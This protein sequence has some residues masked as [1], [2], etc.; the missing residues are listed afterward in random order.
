MNRCYKR[1]CSAQPARKGCLPGRPQGA[2]RRSLV[3]GRWWLVVALWLLLLAGCAGARQ[4]A[5]PTSAPSAA[6]TRAGPSPVPT[7]GPGQFANPV[8]AQDFPDPD[9]LKVGDTYYAYATNA[10]G[11]NVQVAES[12]D[13]VAWRMLGDALPA[14]PAWA[15]PG[16][17]WA[18]EIAQTAGGQGFVLY[19]TARE[20]QSQR[21]C[22]GAATS[23]T[24]QGPFRAAGDAPLVCQRDEGG[25]IDPASFVDTDGTRYLLWKSDGNCCGLDTWLY[26]QRVSPD[27]LTLE[28]QPTRLIKQD[29]IWEGRLVEAPTLWKRGQT[30]YLFYS[31]NNYA[32]MDYAVGYATAAQPLGPYRKSPRPLAAS[33]TK[34]AVVIGPGGQD[35]AVAPDGSTWLVYHAWDTDLTYR[36]MNIDRLE[37]RD[38]TPVL[39]G[40]STGPQALP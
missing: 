9:T 23:P 14:L 28:G 15:Q 5:A 22:I 19:F 35:V 10:G 16:F 37:W 7:P 36:T 30:Y 31:A 4:A 11:A 29:Q 25:S 39:D 32:G 20:E 18:P 6:P 34:G 12:R 13:L 21:Q 17:T 38:E 1:V 2:G 3:V 40:P 24:P 33:R 26:I 8:I 27:G